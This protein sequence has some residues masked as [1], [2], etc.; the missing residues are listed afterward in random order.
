M[1]VLSGVADLLSAGA[2]GGILG[3]LGSGVNRVMKFKEREQQHK[4][5][6]QMAGIDERADNRRAAISEREDERLHKHELALHDLNLKN[7]KAET[8][9]EVLMTREAG[10]WKAFEASHNTAAVEAENFDGSQWVEDYKAATR[11]SLT[12]ALWLIVLIA[13]FFVGDAERGE[14]IKAAIFCATAST[15][16]WFGDRAPEYKQIATGGA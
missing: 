3:I 14:I 4:H 7:M 13:F 1:G 6:L 8:E 16:W 15:L 12:F 9:R 2:S 10:S 11:P 5:D